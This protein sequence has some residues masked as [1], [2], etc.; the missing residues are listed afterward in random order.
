MKPFV[1]KSG[2]EWAVQCDRCGVFAHGTDTNE[3]ANLAMSHECKWLLGPP[4]KRVELGGG[5]SMVVESYDPRPHW[6]YGPTRSE[7]W[8]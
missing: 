3:A 6:Y 4:V 5:T 2:R 8:I 1:Y 7:V